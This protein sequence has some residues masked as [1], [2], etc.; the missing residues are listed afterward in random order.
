MYIRDSREG[1]ESK[2]LRQLYDQRLA[3]VIKSAAPGWAGLYED[4]AVQIAV[5]ES[6]ND[7]YCHEHTDKDDV[8][9]QYMMC[10][11][12]YTGGKLRVRDGEPK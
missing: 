10:L 2:W 3:P 7:D 9:V 5:Y 8:D 4:F 12:A 6:S 1:T 11:G